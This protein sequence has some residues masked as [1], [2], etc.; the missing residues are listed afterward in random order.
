ML[1]EQ[2]VSLVN[3]RGIDLQ[4]V[5]GAS[6]NTKGI[7]KKRQL[8]LAELKIRHEL[9]SALSVEPTALGTQTRVYK[10]P[11]NAP[12]DMAYTLGT[13]PRM[14]E[15][16]F[17]YSMA[18]WLGAFEELHVG[19]MLKALSIISRALKNAHQEQW[20]M[21]VRYKGLGPLNWERVGEP[22]DY[23]SKL[24]T[25]VLIEDARRNE[26][27]STP[28]LLADMMGVDKV[29]WDRCL[30]EHFKTLRQHY[31]NWYHSAL[32]TVQRNRGMKAE[33]IEA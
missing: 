33:E 23:V 2:F 15:L 26:F 25:L 16:A 22:H 28:V 5:A 1:I 24:A 7:A 31:V 10:R 11:I 4:F 17:Y 12:S 6:L 8:S 32:Y 13:V 18:G 19:L 29:M 20:P 27:I 21:I 30:V 3:A 14:P 9:K